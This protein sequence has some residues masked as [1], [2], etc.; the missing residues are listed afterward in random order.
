MEYIDLIISEYKKRQE[1]E[2][3]LDNRPCLELPIPEY[4]EN[5]EEEN[6]EPRRVI[7][8]EL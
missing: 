8:I 4:I 7:V 6:Q 2:E 5:K 1:Q 3:E